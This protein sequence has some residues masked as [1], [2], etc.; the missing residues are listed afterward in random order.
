MSKKYTTETFIAKA[1]EIHGDKYDYSDVVYKSTKEKVCIICPKHGQFW[2]VAYEHLHG[3]GCK[4]CA[5]EQLFSKKTKS[6]DK[7][8]EEAKRIHGN[9][10]DYSKVKY[11]GAHKKVRVIC[12]THGEFEQEAIAHLRG[13]GCPKC[14]ITKNTI[15]R[16]KKLKDFIDEANKIHECKYDYSKVKYINACTK[17]CIICPIHGEFYIQPNHHLEGG[18]CQKCVRERRIKNMTSSN[19]EFITKAKEVH[20]DKYDYSKVE[21]ERSNKKVCIICPIH[22]EFWQ[23]PNQHLQG[24]GCHKCNES[25]LERDISL[26]LDKE[27]ISYENE[28]MFEWLGRK[29]IDFYLSQY[30]TVIECQGLQHF[31]EVEHFGGIDNLNEVIESDKL[32]KKLCEEHGIKMLYYSDLNIDYPYKVFTDK[33]ELINEIKKA[34][35]SNN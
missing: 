26:L 32:K 11:K 13:Q 1:K 17:V 22:G 30:N 16:S 7:F 33:G 18:E 15:S 14:G 3:S 4:K 9:K 29:R 12:P 27:N 6:I 24:R 19:E 28:K 31:K 5:M 10:Y 34:A 25:R 21:Y 35:E 8:I 23:T 20:G 2:Q